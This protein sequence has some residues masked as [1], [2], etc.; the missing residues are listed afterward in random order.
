MWFYFIVFFIIIGFGAIYKFK[1]TNQS[2]WLYFFL[3]AFLFVIAGFRGEGVD[4]DYENYIK[5]IKGDGAFTEP[6]FSLISYLCYDLLDS[7]KLVFIIYA[8]LSVSLL[9]YGLKKLSPYFFLSLAVYYSTSYVIH[10][11]NAIRAG[12]GVGFAFIALDHW[13]NGRAK[14]T[15]LFLVLA[16]F[17]HIS[18]SMF[19]LFY[20]FLKD[21]KKFL[22][23]Y[24][25]LIPIAYF[26]YFIRIDA[27][28]LLMMVPIPQVQTL[29]LAYSEWNTD[30]V[31]SVNVFS[32]FV[33]IKLLVFIIL[34]MF[35][36]PLS[37]KFKG[38]YLYL[39]MYSLGFFLLIFLAALPGA[40]FRSS[41]LLWISECLLLPMLVVVINPRWVITIL[42]IFFCVF[43]VWLNYVHSDFVRPYNFNFEL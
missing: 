33:V 29:A 23:G 4:N 43:M 31:S 11:L 10:D 26:A 28:S 40:A 30:V 39:K 41:D 42:I 21:D 5:A 22:T 9:F 18:F 19:F 27:L 16:T 34:V 1:L 15:F 38:F 3:W 12:V 37:A 25:L 13:I 24:I 14:K 8:L 35:K 32:V 17:F 20:F 6:S 36:N 2:L 7:T